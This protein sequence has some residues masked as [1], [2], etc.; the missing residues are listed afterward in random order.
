MERTM[1][2]AQVEYAVA[3]YQQTGQRPDSM[4]LVATICSLGQILY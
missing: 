4:Q 1:S 3:T 2:P